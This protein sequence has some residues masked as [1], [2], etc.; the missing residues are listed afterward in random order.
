MG[1]EDGVG[2]GGEAGLG[3]VGLA[4]EVEDFGEVEGDGLFLDGALG[5]GEEGFPEGEGFGPEGGLEVVVGEGVAVGEVETM[6]GEGGGL[7]EGLEHG[8]VEVGG[9]PGTALEEGI[10]GLGEEGA[11]LEVV[12]G[13]FGGE[14]DGGEVVV[15]GVERLALFGEVVAELVFDEGDVGVEFVGLEQVHGGLAAFVEVGVGEEE[16]VADVAGGEGGVA[17]EEGLVVEDEALEGGAEVFEFG[18]GF[19]LVGLFEEGAL[20][21]DEGAE[22]GGGVGGG[23]GG[24]G[25]GGAGLGGGG[26]EG[27]GGESEGEQEAGEEARHGGE[28]VWLT[29]LELFGVE[30]FEGD[31]DM[32]KIL[33]KGAGHGGGAAEEVVFFGEGSEVA[34][35][36]GEVDEAL[37]IGDV[38]DEGGEG[39]GS[40]EGLEF[41]VV[42]GFVGALHAVEDPSGGGAFL[43]AGG[44]EEAEERSDADAAGE[45]DGGGAGVGPEGVGEVAVGSPEAGGGAGFEVLDAGSPVAEGFDGEA[46]GGGLGG[47]G[48]GERVGFAADGVGVEGDVEELAGLVGEGAFDGLEGEVG[49]VVADGGDG[50]D[51]VIVLGADPA[52]EEADVEVGGEAEGAPEGEP[53]AEGGIAHDFAVGEDAVGD[54]EDEE[55]A[56]EIVG[57]FPAVVGELG[58]E[59]EDD[60]EDEAGEGDEAGVDGDGGGEEVAKV[61]CGAVGEAGGGEEDGVEEDEDKG[62][63]ADEAVGLVNFIESAEEAFDDAEAGGEDEGPAHEQGGAVTADLGG[64]FPGVIIPV[65][66]VGHA[67]EPETVGNEQGGQDGEE[68]EVGG[69]SQRV[70]E[71]GAEHSARGYQATRKALA[72][73]FREGVSFSGDK[74][75]G[76]VRAF[77]VVAVKASCGGETMNTLA[78]TD[79]LAALNWRY[80][81]K[82]FDPN[83]KI[84]AE[85]WS[86]LEQSLVLAPSSFGLQPWK[87]I[88][89]ESPEVRAALM[90][91]TWGQT[92]TVDASHYVVLAYKRDLDEG[93]VGRY[94][95]RTAEVRGVAVESMDAFKNVILGALNGARKAGALDTWQSRQVYIAL[96]QFMTAAA[97]LGIDTCPIEGL[98]PAQYDEILGLKGT[99]WATVCACAA[100]YRDGG[101]KYATTPKVRFPLSEVIERR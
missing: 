9:G 45:E 65:G 23:G 44:G 69:V 62:G 71:E 2:D 86:A 68:A 36:V 63:D 99:P 37:L 59:G 58:G 46:E 57:L 72:Q 67:A 6:G 92:Q 89:V 94:M 77:D 13:F 48:D 33:A 39:E 5:A 14:G 73:R 19:A 61:G 84:P 81:T 32:E 28:R 100:G 93:H 101:D 15:E 1:G 47:A 54:D 12:E 16:G 24:G 34:S 96:G 40:D 70:S 49:D 78:T 53:E 17:A 56:E 27:G 95:E 74:W 76:V 8:R 21:I 4:E 98:V 66:V 51:E 11:D 29:D 41:V 80:A 88:V 91:A 35:E 55:E 20:A 30:M 38:F 22:G 50:G 87:F 82:V 97:L 60:E 43:E 85:T 83:R 10:A 52:V 79:L 18:G 7:G 75:V 31:A 3:L 64:V 90:P 42:N 26:G 25:G